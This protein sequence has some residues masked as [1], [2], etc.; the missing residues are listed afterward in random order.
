[1]VHALTR[2]GGDRREQ[3]MRDLAAAPHDLAA[4][5]AAR[6]AIIA[7]GGVIYTA[8]VAETHRQRALSALRPIDPAGRSELAALL[9]ELSPLQR[10]GAGVHAEDA[11]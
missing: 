10:R 7:T 9:A 11:R 3:L 6:A 5:D 1:M 2:L 8:I 4:E